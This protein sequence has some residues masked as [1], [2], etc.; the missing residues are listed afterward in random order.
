VRG[1]PTVWPTRIGEVWSIPTMLRLGLVES[2]RRMALR[3]AARLQEVES[4]DRSAATLREAS[5]ESPQALAAALAAFVDD[6]PPFTPT[7][8]ARFLQQ[9]RSYQTNC[10]PLI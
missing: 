2:I 7:W 8:V 1:D 3:V 9:V 6:H 5:E 4:A 10:T